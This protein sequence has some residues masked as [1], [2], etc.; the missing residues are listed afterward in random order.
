MMKVEKNKRFQITLPAVKFSNLSMD[1]SKRKGL[2]WKNGVGA[3]LTAL[4]AT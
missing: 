2:K 3:V 1:S 4:P